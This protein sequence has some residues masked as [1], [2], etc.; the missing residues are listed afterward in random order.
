M[1][2]I[3][4]NN[5]DHDDELDDT[6][7]SKELNSCVFLLQDFLNMHARYVLTISINSLSIVS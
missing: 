4:F 5:H 3:N 2:M 1:N 7:I 6:M